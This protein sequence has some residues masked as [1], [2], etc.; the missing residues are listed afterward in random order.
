MDVNQ[1]EA[2]QQDQDHAPEGM[3]EKALDAVVV[4]IVRVDHRVLRREFVENP[5][6]DQLVAAHDHLVFLDFDHRRLDCGDGGVAPGDGA[7]RVKFEIAAAVEQGADQPGKRLP[8]ELD[9]PDF[10]TVAQQ[11]RGEVVDRLGAGDDLAARPRLT[12]AADGVDDPDRQVFR[13]GGSFGIVDNA[14]GEQRIEFPDEFVLEQLIVIEVGDDL[15]GR[16]AQRRQR[17]IDGQLRRDV[18]PAI[19]FQLGTAL[20]GGEKSIE[21]AP[22]LFIARRRNPVIARLLERGFLAQSGGGRLVLV[23]E[24]GPGENRRRSQLVRHQLRPRP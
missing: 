6:A 8:V 18:N 21:V 20:R 9:R 24:I 13:H 15:E 3:L 14:A 16:G 5:G 12:V 7:L 23:G 22:D 10:G 19:L 4:L 2:G 17:L 1:V 11:Q